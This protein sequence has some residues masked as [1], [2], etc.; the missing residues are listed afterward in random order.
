VP[1]A[2]RLPPEQGER[3]TI[4][5][6]NRILVTGA[7][8]FVGRTLVETLAPRYRLRLADRRGAAGASPAGGE[9]VTVGEIGPDT[10]WQ[11]AVRDVD[12][13]VHLAAHVHQ[14]GPAG[15]AADF[16]RVNAEGT[17]CLAAA[18][19]SAGVRHIVFL[20]SVKVNGEATGNVPFREADA[21]Q[22][23][24]PYA[25]SKWQAE[26][27]LTGI[28]QAGG[29]AVTILRPPL[30]YGPGAKA[31]FRA[32]A[33]LCRL[34]VPLPLGAID[35]RRSLIFLGNLVA[36]IERAV[37]LPPDAGSRTFLL[38][39]GEDL[40]TTELVRR[41]GAALGRRPPLVPVP[42][43]WLRLALGALG[44]SA[45]AD[46][47]LGSLAVDDSRIRREL[48]WVPPFSVDQGL[49]ATAASFR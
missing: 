18:A 44:R 13:V 21:P 7:S 46:R 36:A 5:S 35:N 6:V 38:R 1:L 17:R 41:L 16:F 15:N 2:A 10:D 33:R 23:Q 27:A 25:Q 31:N 19:R 11:R 22:P 12:Q 42:P 4:H 8:S 3:Y 45:A 47:L 26:Q 30:V 49:A 40:S 14:T 29:P 48:A 43:S 32:L 39:D 9:R 28:A 37:A 34:G 20:S 24:G